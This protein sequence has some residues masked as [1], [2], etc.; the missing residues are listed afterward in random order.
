MAEG[1]DMNAE[2]ST[3]TPETVSQKGLE[4][5]DSE[6]LRNHG[7]LYGRFLLASQAKTEKEAANIINP[8][9][10]VSLL[11]DL[12]TTDNALT[13]E[14]RNYNFVAEKSS[15]NERKD[16]WKEV[17]LFDDAYKQWQ[18]QFT[19]FMKNNIEQGSNREEALRIIM[20]DPKTKAAEFT[21]EKARGLFEKFCKDTSDIHAF[22]K[23][24]TENLK[25]N[26]GKIDST[27]L[28]K[29]LPDLQWIAS[30]LFGKETASNAVTRLIEL[31]SAMNNDINLVLETVLINEQ[32]H[33]PTDD[34]KQIL[35]ALYKG[36]IPSL[37]PQAKR[38]PTQESKVAVPIVPGEGVSK[39][40][41][42]PK[43]D[44]DKI[45][46]SPPPPTVSE[47]REGGS[48]ER[49]LAGM[50]LKGLEAVRDELL[51]GFSRKEQDR[52]GA[53]ALN[54]TE[55]Q[56]SKMTPEERTRIQADKE[57]MI[58]MDIA[59]LETIIKEGGLGNAQPQTAEG[60]VEE[61]TAEGMEEIG[62]IS[63]FSDRMIAWEHGNHRIEIIKQDD[64]W[65]VKFDDKLKFFGIK[66]NLS[67]KDIIDLATVIEGF[68]RIPGIDTAEQI[69]QAFGKMFVENERN[70]RVI[71]LASVFKQLPLEQLPSEIYIDGTPFKYVVKDGIIVN[72]QTAESFFPS[73]YFM[74]KLPPGTVR[75]INIGVGK[76]LLEAWIKSSPTPA[77][78]D[79]AAAASDAAPTTPAGIIPEPETDEEKWNR[80]NRVSQAIRDRE[81]AE[82]ELEAKETTT[83][84]NIIN[85]DFID[86]PADLHT[87]LNELLK[88]SDQDN[89]TF[90]FSPDQLKNIS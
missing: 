71:F 25:G 31:E 3:E 66:D 4:I 24:V 44:E 5:L 62:E 26:D 60:S 63:S 15:L 70:D 35:N 84:E 89:I 81:I 34:E 6:K 76:Y 69:Y 67:S 36:E 90:I 54:M 87:D 55:D 64:R 83:A 10:T 18:E 82:W 73:A 20:S 61:K 13:L 11:R 19:R 27:K 29:L 21:E 43:P 42:I 58:R 75:S 9:K 47:S 14:K 8:N 17:P 56:I 51:S 46:P 72:N 68:K 1:G 57:E 32:R 39:P 12:K 22:V 41:P 2:R 38:V 59:N 88:T 52:L 80:M 16:Q 45:P 86:N 50:N 77:K 74:K 30:G 23:S 78:S 7:A 85:M 53:Q 33:N 48:A 79:L 65:T 37:I 40:A 49:D 28:E